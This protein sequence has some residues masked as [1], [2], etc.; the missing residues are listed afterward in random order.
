MFNVSI[1]ESQATAF[2][3]V[4]DNYNFNTLHAS[5]FLWT[6]S[7]LNNHLDQHYLLSRFDFKLMILVEKLV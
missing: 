7:D 6:I 5:G 1:K 4:S 3:R 2:D